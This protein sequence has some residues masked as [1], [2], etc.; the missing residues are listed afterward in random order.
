MT[1]HLRENEAFGREN[2]AF[3]FWSIMNEHFL[4]CMAS[5]LI[6]RY[7]PECRLLAIYGHAAG[8]RI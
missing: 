1:I 4:P 3:G 6:T 7:S 2:E 8:G 5:Q